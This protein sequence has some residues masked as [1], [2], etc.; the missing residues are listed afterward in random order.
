MNKD[1]PEYQDYVFEGFNVR[2]NRLECLRYLAFSAEEAYAT[3]Q[4]LQPDFRILSYG[5][6]RD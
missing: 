1:T 2:R 4:R 3:C 6:A 5:L